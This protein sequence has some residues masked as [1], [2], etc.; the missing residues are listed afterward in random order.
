MAS[1]SLP[2]RRHLAVVDDD[3]NGATGDSIEDNCDSVTNVNND[4]D[5]DGEMDDY[6]DGNDGDA[7]GNGTMDD[8]NNDNDGNVDGDGAMDDNDDDNGNDCDGRQ[9]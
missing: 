7:D 5:Y 6:D 1:L 9:R 2:M 3:G 4:D 8:N